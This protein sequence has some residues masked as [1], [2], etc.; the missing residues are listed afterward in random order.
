MAPVPARI[1]ASRE[2]AARLGTVLAA[3]GLGLVYGGASVGLMGR[4]ADAALAAGG[5][6]IGVIP[7][8]LVDMEVA[9]GGLSD[10]R[11]VTTMHER[12]AVMADLA[13]AFIALP[14]GIGTLDE[15]F[16]ILTW[17]QLGLHSKPIG[18]LDRDDYFAPLLDLSR[19]A[20]STRRFVQ[21][22]HRAMLLV[23]DDPH[24]LLAACEAYVPPPPF[25]WVDREPPKRLSD[26]RSIRR[27]RPPS[28]LPPQGGKGPVKQKGRFNRE[29]AALNSALRAERAR[30]LSG[31][32]PP[33]GGRSG[34]GALTL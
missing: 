14:G 25:K 19:S 3:R 33:C 22:A 32:F 34:W 17:A 23:D 28:D 16:E 2:L 8:A 18:L 20:P 21:P 24:R 1:P 4:L 10:L 6:V 27:H 29:R 12:K 7:R 9:H 15:L 31:S 11:V 13:D 5:E 26:D 30:D